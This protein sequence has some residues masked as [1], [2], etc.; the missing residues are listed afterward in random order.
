MGEKVGLIIFS[1][2][3]TLC[4]FVIGLFHGWS[5]ALA[6]TAVGPAIGICAVCYGKM[7][8][9]TSAEGLK[10]YAQSAGYAEQ[11]LSAIRVVVAFGMEKMEIINYNKYL[12]RSKEMGRRQ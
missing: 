11:A 8:N 12:W 2:G 9:K 5:L 4:G 6:M 7:L 1:V 10:A 3:M